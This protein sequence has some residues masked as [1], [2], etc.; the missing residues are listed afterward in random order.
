[1]PDRGQHAPEDLGLDQ[2][3]QRQPLDREQRVEGVAGVL[4]GREPQA[5]DRAQ[6]DALAHR[7]PPYGKVVK[8]RWPVRTRSAWCSKA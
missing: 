5:D 2:A 8:I 7:V 6:D 1:V 4:Q 3:A